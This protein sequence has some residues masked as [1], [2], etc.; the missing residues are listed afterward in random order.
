M[1]LKKTLSIFVAALLLTSTFIFAAASGADYTVSW[2]LLQ[3]VPNVTVNGKNCATVQGMCCD[4]QYAYVAKMSGNNGYTAL[5]RVDLDTGER[6]LLPFYASLDAEEPSPCGILSHANGMAAV[7]VNGETHLFVATL[8]APSALVRLLV[9][10]GSV[11]YVCAY[12]VKTNGSVSDFSAIDHVRNEGGK[13]YLLGKNRYS[14]YSCVVDEAFGAVSNPSPVE[15]MC[16]VIF[17]IDT[18]NAQFFDE[19]SESY[20]IDN[21]EGWVNQGS[22]F[23]RET[24]MLYV[25]VWRRPSSESAIIVFDASAAVT[26]E[27]MKTKA[28]SDRLIFPCE[29]SIHINNTELKSFELEDCDLRMAPNGEGKR[30]LYFATNSTTAYEGVFVTD[31]FSGKLPRNSIVGKDTV[32]YTIRYDANGGEGSMEITRHLSGVKTNLRE[33]NFS[34]GSYSFGGWR[35]RRSSDGA[36]LCV[37]RNGSKVW[38][39]A[40]RMPPGSSLAVLKDRQG[41]IDLTREQG[42]EIVAFA[43][44][45]GI[46]PEDPPA[47]PYADLGDFFV[48]LARNIVKAF[49]KLFAYFKNL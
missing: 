12:S 18:R 41:V 11:Y 39:R 23:D 15:I 37:L 43:F 32:I 5:F 34:Y 46:T 2:Q 1:K 6:T 7:K 28:D 35:L 26:P 19:K 47:E 24:G 16:P 21:L 29:A 33:L 30:F 14:Y 31:V 48:S 40:N 49:Q 42:D 9:R 17:T 3:T 27:L 8:K 20:R 10:N 4:E 22:A 38:R 25:P 13:I 45:K 44:W 36:W